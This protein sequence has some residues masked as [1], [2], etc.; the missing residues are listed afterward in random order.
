MNVSPLEVVTSPEEF[1]KRLREHSS[2]DV[3]LPAVLLLLAVFV[4]NMVLTLI[5]QQPQAF[6]FTSV[7]IYLIFFAALLGF[8]VLLARLGFA[9]TLEVVGYSTVPFLIASVLFGTL[10]I[11]GAT[12]LMIGQ[13]LM[14]AG[15]I[16]GWLRLYKGL[17]VMT[18]ARPL[19][20]RGAIASPLA[21][22]LVV[23]FS[24]LLFRLL[25]LA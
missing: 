13:A 1:F 9:R 16:M 8:V 19:A 21:S 11:L 7:V 23:G 20:L 12:G 15:L 18:D 25:G 4:P 14:L 24:G 10:S 6:L 22:F 3:T 5:N 2:N 17:E